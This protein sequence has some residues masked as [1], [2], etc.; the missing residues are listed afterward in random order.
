VAA[1]LARASISMQRTLPTLAALVLATAACSRPARNLGEFA[2]RIEDFRADVGVP[3]LSAAIARDGRIV[4]SQGFGS[5][6]LESGRPATPETVYHL[7]SLTKTFASVVLLQ[8]AAEG[9][10]SRPISMTAIASRCSTR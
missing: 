2:S 10:L 3:G 4:W 5:A 1:G 9:R 6:D 8:L 7:A